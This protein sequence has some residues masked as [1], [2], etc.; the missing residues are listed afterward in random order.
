MGKASRQKY[1]EELA[2]RQAANKR[3]LGK[4]RN[5]FAIITTSAVAVMAAVILVVVVIGNGE[6]AKPAPAPTSNVTVGDVAVAID[7]D[8]GAIVIGDGPVDVEEYL[9]FGCSHCYNFYMAYGENVKQFVADDAIT[10]S[11][12]PLGMLDNSFM[13]TKFSTRSANALYCV[14]ESAPDKVFDFTGALF[15][16]QPREGTPGLTN[17]RLIEIANLSGAEAATACI[18][19]ETYNDFVAEKT[20][21]VLRADWFRGTPGLRVNG[22]VVN[23]PTT[24]VGAIENAI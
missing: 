19:D 8:T 7:Q 12:F 17:E 22:E 23:D 9:D 18:A 11:I 13:G 6:K 10:L 20:L 21:K 16:N 15:V 24:F 14:A 3:G 2:A 1:R 4:D 5:W